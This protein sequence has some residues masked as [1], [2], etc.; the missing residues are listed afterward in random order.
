VFIPS[1]P[2]QPSLMFADEA[3]AYTSAPL[4]CSALGVGSLAYPH[5]LDSAKKTCQGQTPQLTTK[6][7]ITVVIFCNIALPV[8][9]TN[10]RL[11]RKGLP[12]T[13][14][15]AYYKIC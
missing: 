4:K 10:I 3:G 11:R 12:G 6:L 15:P 14:T 13:N 2:L 9:P 7:L 5:T 8:L 1:K